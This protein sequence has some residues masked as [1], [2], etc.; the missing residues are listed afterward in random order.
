M[1]HWWESISS[2]LGISRALTPLYGDQVNGTELFDL[3]IATG[4]YSVNK[5]DG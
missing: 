3:E 1:T 5:A 4:R 2:R